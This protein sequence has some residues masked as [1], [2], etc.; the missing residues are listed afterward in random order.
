VGQKVQPTGFRIGITDDWRSRWYAKKKD[1]GGLLIEDQK[2][3]DYVKREYGFAG[4]PRVDVERKTEGGCY[5][6]AAPQPRAELDRTWR[7]PGFTQSDRHPVVCVTWHDANAYVA[8]LAKRTGKAYRLLS[9]SEREYVARAGTTTPFWWGGEISTDQANYNGEFA[10]YGN[11]AKGAWRR[12]TVPVDTF[13][14][15]PW[16]LF[17]VHGNVWDWTQD[18][19]NGTHAGNPGDGRA[20]L[21]GD[22]SLRATRGG[23][24]NNAP[25]TVRSARRN[26]EPAGM[27]GTG[28][29]FRVARAL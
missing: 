6:L 14:P 11:G 1:F 5:D 29:G 19:W 4:I 24:W 23:S 9:E 3:R 10:V 8:W 21:R 7:D 15:N 18:C 20:R 26:M 13:A 25:Q 17:N 16:G 2:I 22:C 12:T 28:I 27:R